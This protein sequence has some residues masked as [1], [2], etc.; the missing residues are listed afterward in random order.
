M[1]REMVRYRWLEEAEGEVRIKGT[2]ITVRD[3]LESLEAGYSVKE[4]AEEYRIQEE[5]V[6]EA[7]RFALDRLSHRKAS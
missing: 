2:R 6:K 1:E 3:V 4:I 7:V 5:A